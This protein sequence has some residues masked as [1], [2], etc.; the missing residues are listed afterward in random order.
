MSRHSFEDDHDEDDCHPCY[1]HHE[2][3]D[4]QC[5]LSSSSNSSLR[6]HPFSHASPTFAGS[7]ISYRNRSS[8]D[9]NM[10]TGEE[11]S[12]FRVIIVGGNIAGLMLGCF[13]QLAGID[14][15]ILESGLQDALPRN[16]IVLGSFVMNLLE[17]VGLVEEAI[18]N[19]CPMMAMKFWRA[20]ATECESRGH[21][22]FSGAEKRYAY[23]GRSIEYTELQR[24][25]M[26]NIPPN[27]ILD[28]QTVVRFTQRPHQVD[29]QCS[30]A[31]IHTGTILVGADGYDSTIRQ[32]LYEDLAQLPVTPDQPESFPPSELEPLDTRCCISGSAHL[33]DSD[34]DLFPNFYK[35]D[36]E[37]LESHVI[38]GADVPF[39]WW[40]TLH[41]SIQK[42]SWLITYDKLRDTSA[43]ATA[44]PSRDDIH[45]QE[46][47]Q[48]FFEQMRPLLTSLGGRGTL[49]DLMDRTDPLRIQRFKRSGRLWDTWHYGRVV[50][51]GDACHKLVP[52]TGQGALQAMLDACQL[53]IA[54]RRIY[55][56]TEPIEDA[57]DIAFH[58]YF[59]DRYPHTR[60]A[61]LHS[62][63]IDK[64]IGEP[65]PFRVIIVGAGLG[66]LLLALQLERSS[67]DY[68][69]VERNSQALMPMEGG[70]VIFVQKV[71]Q[72]LL[73][74]LGLFNRVLDASGL[75]KEVH[76]KEFSRA[77]LCRV[78][79][80][81]VLAITRPEL[82]NILVKQVPPA[83]LRL[84]KTV[85]RIEQVEH[86]V[87]CY[88]TEDGSSF[89]GDILVG[90]DGTYS[91]V[92]LH[93]LRQLQSQGALSDSDRLCMQS[94]SIRLVGQATELDP[95]AFTVEPSSQHGQRECHTWAVQFP[96]G[97]VCWMIDQHLEVPEDC[98][99]LEDLTYH[100]DLVEAMCD[101]FRALPSAWGPS[102]PHDVFFRATLPN[103]IGRLGRET[104]VY[105]TWHLGRIVLMGDACHK[106]L[107]YWGHPLAQAALDS[108]TLHKALQAIAQHQLPTSNIDSILEGY[109]NER[110][111]E[112]RQALVSSHELHQ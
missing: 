28:R 29:V 55:D 52:Y 33:L 96:K 14:F 57:M 22:D 98:P 40:M 106:A 53:S 93:I 39:S 19:S 42:I 3:E 44:Q 102:V 109:V 21:I 54:I 64:I 91:A 45:R 71:V 23:N 4:L 92:R 73:E 110:M 72:T 83:K 105:D 66:G 32:L 61:V 60:D 36:F 87:R 107:P 101:Q 1:R 15:V 10:T 7:S 24:I 62:R 56:S 8:L 12:P 47:V 26:S 2:K 94:D 99:D 86:G 38:T 63:E 31:T 51:M 88:C 97:N 65:H 85:E 67:I 84:G 18:A 80:Q 11:Q 9:S 77:T 100:A 20:S 79:H 49:G 74:K 89:A 68:V 108:I 6:P 27:Q 112:A 41:P 46:L 43:A 103:T 13:L 81:D 59:S 17:K 82:Y 25:L 75:V 30:D 69:I 78:L 34:E 76:V 48:D 5:H 58:E 111:A 16:P 95:S 104:K 50:L 70:G 37:S 35:M 90:A